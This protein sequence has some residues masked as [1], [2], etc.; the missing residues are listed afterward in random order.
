L[1]CHQWQ[2]AR[3]YI[4]RVVVGEFSSYQPANPVTLLKVY[5]GPQVYFQYLIL[6]LHLPVR[7]RIEGSAQSAFNTKPLAELSPV[8]AGE[9]QTSVGDNTSR[10]ACFENNFLKE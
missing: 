9:E 7:L 4:L 10:S 3:R 2:V 6:A 5:K 1:P 8:R